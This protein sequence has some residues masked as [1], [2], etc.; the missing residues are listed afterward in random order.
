M[1][2]A[3][4][5]P[6]AGVV[7]WASTQPGS[8]TTSRPRRRA[9]GPAR[10]SRSLSCSASPPRSASRTTLHATRR[11][12]LR[13]RSAAAGRGGSEAAGRGRRRRRHRRHGRGRRPGRV[14]RRV[15]RRR[16]RPGLGAPRRAELEQPLDLVAGVVGPVPGR[17]GRRPRGAHV[18]D[19]AAAAPRRLGRHRGAAQRRR[20]SRSPR[21]ESSACCSGSEPPRLALL[22]CAEALRRLEGDERAAASALAV[23][24]PVYLLHALADIDWDFVAAS[25]PVLFAVGV[26]LAAGRH[27]PSRG[28][29]RRWRSQQGS[30]RSASSTR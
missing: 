19:R 4:V 15:P 2:V 16:R 20:S 26:L 29:V 23:L 21:R 22:A 18:R 17:A 7:A 25:A 24:L 10:G 9:S 12:A 28:A 6:A 30:P 1:L 8:S 11:A 13:R 14:A 5:V 3:A 27:R